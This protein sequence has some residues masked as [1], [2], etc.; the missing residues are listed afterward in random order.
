[1]K[2]GDRVQGDGPECTGTIEKIRPSSPSS[3]GDYLVAEV[4][5]DTGA[6]CAEPLEW[7]LP[8]EG[9]KQARKIANEALKRMRR[10]YQEQEG[11]SSPT[12]DT[13]ARWCAA[14]EKLGCKEI[15]P[16]GSNP[17]QT[18]HSDACRKRYERGGDQKE[19][20]T[21]WGN[22]S[23]R[24]DRGLSGTGKEAK[25]NALNV[26]ECAYKPCGRPFTGRGKYHSDACRQAAYRARAKAT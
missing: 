13:P 4:L 8:L 11:R 15:I 3:D 6:R 9:A 19:V 21:H 24:T 22:A 2:V 23:T 10:M 26:N 5:W 1:M 16:A 14:R 17:R 20:S 12:F 25:R 7:L 18:F